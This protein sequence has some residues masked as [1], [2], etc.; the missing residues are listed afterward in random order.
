[1][2]ALYTFSGVWGAL[3]VLFDEG[4]GNSG[5]ASQFTPSGSRFPVS[6]TL[7]VLTC[8]LW[9]MGCEQVS[10]VTPERGSKVTDISGLFVTA[11]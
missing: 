4:G 3:L 11:A 1:M 6:L 10:D 9:P 5:C 2:G 8:V 7:G